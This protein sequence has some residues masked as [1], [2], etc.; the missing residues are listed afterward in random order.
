MSTEPSSVFFLFIHVC[1]A[2]VAYGSPKP[3]MEVRIF[4]S[5]QK[6]TIMKNSKTKIVLLIG[7]TIVT[8]GLLSIGQHN[9]IVELKKNQIELDS[10]RDE[11]FILGV[12]LGRYEI[13]LDH[14]RETNPKVAKEFEEFMFHE[15][16]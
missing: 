13:T 14:L 7:L 6:T 8:L 1:G 2:M 3:L 5:V 16:E 10:L 15:T 4:P 12:E 9:Q 11:T